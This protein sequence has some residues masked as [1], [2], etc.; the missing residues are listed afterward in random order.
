MN[1]P[2]NFNNFDESFWQSME[3][4]VTSSE[5]TI[6]RPKGTAHPRYP[7]FIYPVDY[8]YLKGTT[9]IDGHRVDAGEEPAALIK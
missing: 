5:I 2:M 9:A 3:T 6:D 8:G 1:T 7:D 4:L